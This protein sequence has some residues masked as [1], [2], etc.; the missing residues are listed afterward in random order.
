MGKIKDIIL[1]D[2][3]R[4]LSKLLGCCVQFDERSRQYP[5][6]AMVGNK[7]PRNMEWQL[8]TLLNQGREGSCVG[9]GIAHE[10]LA[11]PAPASPNL[12]THEYAKKKIYWLAQKRDGWPGGSYPRAFPRYEGTSVLAGLKAGRELGWYDGFRWAF[13]IDDLIAGIGYEGPAVLGLNWYEGMMQ[14]DH[15]GVIRPTGKVAGRHC[16]AVTA[17]DV[18]DEMFS[19]PQS[20]G[21]SHGD[22]GWVRISFSDMERLLGEDGEAA[23]VVGRREAPDRRG[24]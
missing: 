17:Q 21:R 3:S 1:R 12:V 18:D 8:D 20:W 24:K 19:I 6:R 2:G 23:F 15:D 4:V 10:L 11:M 16:V 22:N 9:H 7:P 14:P 5:V 13:G